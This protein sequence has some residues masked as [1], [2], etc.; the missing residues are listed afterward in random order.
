MN[1][2]LAIIATLSLSQLGA[3]GIKVQSGICRG[4]TGACMAALSAAQLQSQ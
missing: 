4:R 2:R 1:E 3:G